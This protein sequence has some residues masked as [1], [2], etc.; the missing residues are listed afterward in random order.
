VVVVANAVDVGAKV[1]IGISAVNPVLVVVP[2]DSV[3][4]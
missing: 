3:V 1:V 2:S 4:I